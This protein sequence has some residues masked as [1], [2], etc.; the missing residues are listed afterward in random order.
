MRKGLA[1]A[2]LL[3]AAAF[4]G[5]DR[6]EA[7]V[8]STTSVTVSTQCAK[9][10]PLGNG[11]NTTLTEMNGQAIFGKTSWKDLGKIN[12]PATDGANFS[13]AIDSGGKSG[14]WALADGFRFDVAK[15]YALVLKGSSDSAVYLLDVLGLSGTWS[16]A[17]L[18]TG[19]KNPQQ[20]ALSNVTLFGTGNLV[21]VPLPA[22]AWLL[23]SGLG[24]LAVAG[25][26]RKTAAV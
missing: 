8:C 19:G 2:A 26:R 5:A 12:T 21:P 1:L 18:S 6:A 13:I 25:R 23:L 11:G 22:A 4:A 7:A 20:P 9:A 16:T 3:S 10:D 17:D 15:H 24:A 14:T